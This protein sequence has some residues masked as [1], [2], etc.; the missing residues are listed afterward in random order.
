MGSVSYRDPAANLA[1]TSKPTSLVI[2]GNHAQIRGSAK[3]GRRSQVSFTIDA[4][5]N[6]DPGT[7]NDVFSI[8][9]SNGYSAGSN[10]TGGNLRIH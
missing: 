2:S 10:L 6:G 7:P 1:F 3:T 4:T 9:M 5:D 8:N